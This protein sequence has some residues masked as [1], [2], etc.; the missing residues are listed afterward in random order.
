ML[1]NEEAMYI[2][3]KQN[4]FLDKQYESAML[5]LPIY[6]MVKPTNSHKFLIHLLLSMGTFETEISLYKSCNI[7]QCF[8]D[9]GILRDPTPSDPTNVE[10]INRI[11]VKY[12]LE[13]LLYIPTGTKA[14]GRYMIYA[15]IALKQGLINDSEEINET[16]P[17]LNSIL[18]RN[19]SE[20]TKKYIRSLKFNMIQVLKGNL[21]TVCEPTHE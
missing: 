14:I 6:N 15:K 9:S 16:P 18:E 13:Q 11:L 3:E 2:K 8:I 12:I 17:V 5:P 4:S 10:D 21:G 1:N 20:D 19:A 7:K